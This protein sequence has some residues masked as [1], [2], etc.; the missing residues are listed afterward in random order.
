VKV[1]GVHV[2]ALFQSKRR[3]MHLGTNCTDVSE[4]P[5]EHGVNT[6]K[7]VDRFDIIRTLFKSEISEKAS[8]SKTRV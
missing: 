7:T 2:L 5:S 4:L 3:T 8:T 6:R 1:S